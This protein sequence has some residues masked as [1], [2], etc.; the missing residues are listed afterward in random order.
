MFSIQGKI[1]PHRGRGKQLG[2]PTIN[3]PLTKNIR[4]GVYAGYIRYHCTPLPAAIFVG[5]AISFNET[6]AQVEAYVL[7]WSG[8]FPVQEV[9]IEGHSFIRENRKFASTT[10]LQ[11]QIAEDILQV[12]TCLAELFKTL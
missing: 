12:R 4:H 6:E 1:Q 11:K 8:S 5:E 10:E 7:D 3:V 9:V 2:Y